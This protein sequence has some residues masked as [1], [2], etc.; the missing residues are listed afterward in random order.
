MQVE[1]TTVFSDID[2]SQIEAELHESDPMRPAIAAAIIGVS[3]FLG[4]VGDVHFYHNRL[5]LNMLLYVVMLLAAACGLLIYFKCPIALKNLI[6]ALPAILFA[7]CLSVIVAP[8]LVFLNI[9]IMS[10]SLFLAIRFATHPRFLGGNW[11]RPVYTALEA[12]AVGWLEGPLTILRDANRWFWHLELDHHCLATFTAVVRGLLLTLPTLLIFGLLLGS[13]DVVF[14]D[15]LEESFSWLQLTSPANLI[16]H[17]FI[18]GIFSWGCMAV[19]KLM[20]FGSLSDSLQWINTSQPGEKPKALPFRLSMIEST[21]VLGSVDL[22]FLIFVLIQARYL[23]GGEANITAQGYTYAEY[24]RRGFFELLAVSC[25]TMLLAVALDFTTQRK[26]DDR[27]FLGLIAGLVGLTTVI[28]VAALHRLNLYENAYGFTRIRVMS[29]V[30]MIWLGLLF[31]ALLAGIF[32]HR[33]QTFWLGC[34]VTAL[35]F[36]LTLNVMNMDRFIASRNIARFEHGSELD[37]AYLLSLSDD[38]TPAIAP[39]LDNSTLTASQR[40]LLLTGLGE[41]L[42]LLDQDRAE[43]GK[44]GYHVGKARAWQA[45]NPYRTVLEPYIRAPLPRYSGY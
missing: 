29:G 12:A 23:F 8:E 1:S 10:G 32:L 30:F 37:V 43:R 27:L 2:L 26:R 18:I 16:T 25:M 45:L 35:G 14:A 20:M 21:M 34:I 15:L 31:A 4:I 24:A 39:L 9:L 22:L 13:A 3:L 42:Y 19:F 7:A 6:F 5:G 17:V 33:R 36:A 44:L 40:E 41:R 28:L 38:A 11:F